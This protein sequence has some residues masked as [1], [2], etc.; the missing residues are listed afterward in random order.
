MKSPNLKCLMLATVMTMSAFYV[1]T[2]AQPMPAREITERV[3]TC[4]KLILRNSYLQCLIDEETCTLAA[5]SAPLA[6]RQVFLKACKDELEKC[7]AEVEKA[8]K[9]CNVPMKE[10]TE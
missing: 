4:S 2:F 3:K 5:M 8:A 10:I 7:K 6:Q 1:P 9:A